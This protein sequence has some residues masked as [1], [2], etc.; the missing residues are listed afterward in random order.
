MSVEKIVE[1]VTLDITKHGYPF[2]SVRPRGDRNPEQHTISVVFVV[3]DGV[4]AY[5]ERI[6]RGNASNPAATFTNAAES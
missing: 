2:A 3:D 4:R 6:M 5:I 1:D